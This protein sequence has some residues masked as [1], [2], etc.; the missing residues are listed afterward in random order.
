M[1]NLLVPSSWVSAHGGHLKGRSLIHSSVILLLLVRTDQCRDFL[2]LCMNPTVCQWKWFWHST[3]NSVWILKGAYIP[4]FRPHP[5]SVQ[6]P[7]SN[8]TKT[9]NLAIE[10]QIQGLIANG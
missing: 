8:A 1:K 4:S 7:R 6:K 2:K 10:A 5:N 9:K 3:E